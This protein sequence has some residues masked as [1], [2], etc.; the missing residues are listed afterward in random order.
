MEPVP[1]TVGR[2]GGR[3]WSKIGWLAFQLGT[4]RSHVLT[5][6]EGKSEPRLGAI[7]MLGKVLGVSPTWLAFGEGAAPSWW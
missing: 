6:L 1:A 4:G 5:W 2:H 7:K 3:P